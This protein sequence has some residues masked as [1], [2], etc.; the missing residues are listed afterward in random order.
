MTVCRA[1]VAVLSPSP[2]ATNYPPGETSSQ[3][4]A[5]P[6]SARLVPSLGGLNDSPGRV[7]VSLSPP[8]PVG[9]PPGAQ[10]PWGAVRGGLDF[11][12]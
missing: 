4:R 5:G 3:R 11:P 9:T 6:T 2:A 12:I 8:G 1:A 7:C 10:T